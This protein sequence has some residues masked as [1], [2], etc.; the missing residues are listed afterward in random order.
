[1]LKENESMAAR[2]HITADKIKVEYRKPQVFLTGDIFYP[3]MYPEKNDPEAIGYD[4]AIT[5][6]G[7]RWSGLP[8]Q[9]IYQI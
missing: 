2:T 4:V 7:L 1:V 9:F 3:P 8:G 6:G 5:G